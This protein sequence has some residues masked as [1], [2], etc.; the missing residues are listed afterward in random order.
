MFKFS[1]FPVFI[2][3]TPFKY[4]HFFVSRSYDSVKVCHF[5]ISHSYNS[6][7]FRIFPCFSWLQ[8]FQILQ[9]SLFLVAATPPNSTYFSIFRDRDSDN[10]CWFFYFM[11]LRLHYF[12]RFIYF[13]GYDSSIIIHR[14]VAAPPYLSAISTVR[15]F[16]SSNLPHSFNYVSS[17][18]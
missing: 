13:H 12:R 7:K 1:H 2:A 6:A 18:V 9:I 14:M 3:A 15:D 4:A 11:Q 16:V 8:L 17:K 5:P 10:F